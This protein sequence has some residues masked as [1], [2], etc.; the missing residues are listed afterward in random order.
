MGRYWGT[1]ASGSKLCAATVPDHIARHERGSGSSGRRSARAGGAMSTLE[2]IQFLMGSGI[3]T[4]GVGVLKWALQ[5][6][7]RTMAL[8]VSQGLRKA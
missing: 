7:R 4:G 5:I 3:L 8:E 6:E 2:L 1:V